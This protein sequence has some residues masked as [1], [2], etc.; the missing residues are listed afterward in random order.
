MEDQSNDSAK[1]APSQVEEKPAATD[2]QSDQN[3]IFS[4]TNNMV[5][6]SLLIFPI[7]FYDAGLI[8]S[9][10]CCLIYAA[11]NFKSSKIYL[12]HF[13]NK[14]P[15]I[16]FSVRRILGYRY[17]IAF[18]ISS[19]M[20][21]FFLNMIY[22]YYMVDNLSK[23]VNFAIFHSGNE[24]FTFDHSKAHWNQFSLQYLSLVCLVLVGPFLFINDLKVLVKISSYG[25]IPVYTLFLFYFYMLGDNIYLS[26]R[27]GYDILK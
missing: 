10:L 7:L 3:I 27:D 21:L 18:N 23:V 12:Q 5:G 15:D 2:G 24:K 19:V 20:A 8:T 11:V 4:M 14:E 25:V 17:Y 9:V 26:H 22:F 6:G 16:Q 13:K 1:H